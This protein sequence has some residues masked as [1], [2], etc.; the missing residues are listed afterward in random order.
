[1]SDL[2]TTLPDDPFAPFA[3]SDSVPWNLPRAGH[4]LRRLTF[5]ANSKQLDAALKQTPQQ[6]IDSYLDYDPQSDPLAD[7]IERME[8]LM[9]LD[10]PENLQKWWIYRM[11]YTPLPAQEKVALFWHGRFA[12][13]ATKV[14]NVRAL[15]GQIDLFRRRGL[16]SFRDLVVEV[17]HDPAMLTWL[18]GRDSKK[19][20]PNENYARELMEL[21]TLGIGQYSEHDVQELA[22]AFT[23]WK[24]QNG[25]GALEPN[26]FDAGT[27]QIFGQT[28]NFDSESAVDLILQQPAAPKF[29]SRKMLREFVHPDP[30]QEMIDHYAD[31]LIALRWEIKPVLKEMLSSRLFFSPW[32]YRS[33]IKSPAELAIGGALAMGGKIN[34]EFVRQ[35]MNRMG[36]SILFPPNVKGWDGQEAWINANTVLVRFNYGMMLATQREFAKRT[37]L[38]AMLTEMGMTT[39]DQIVDYYARVLHDGKIPPEDRLKFLVYMAR[40]DKGSVEKFTLS[41]N[42]VNSK[43][44]GMIHLMM[45]MPEYQ[46]A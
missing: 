13:S 45:S 41:A 34:M 7:M 1:M 42:S 2:P 20:R 46:L 3:P 11:I 21:F 24:I 43:V 32:A 35:S 23:G 22:R 26:Q 28:G 18:D 25:K 9:N 5:G 30:S 27:K 17:G 36:Q 4:L 16:G 37:D 33:K 38:E 14:S 19:G 44:R 39:S 31:R 40:N 29:L 15:A 6:V 12:T 10:S 8:G